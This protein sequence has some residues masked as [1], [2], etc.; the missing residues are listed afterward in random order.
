M[1]AVSAVDMLVHV[2]FL[3]IEESTG[4]IGVAANEVLKRFGPHLYN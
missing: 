4:I 3:K 2:F 1:I